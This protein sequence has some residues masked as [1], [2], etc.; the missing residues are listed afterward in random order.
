MRSWKRK[1]TEGQP[2]QQSLF[3][4]SANSVLIYKH[5]MC[6]KHMQPRAS[7]ALQTRQN[8]SRRRPP[9]LPTPWPLCQAGTRQLQQDLLLPQMQPHQSLVLPQKQPQ[10]GLLLPQ[11]QPH[12]GLPLPQKQPDQGRPPPQ[13]QAHPETP[14]PQC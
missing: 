5:L 1:H 12:Q 7:C 14:Q 11:M 2:P 3:L 10:Q 8:A 4:T 13:K 6:S 9:G